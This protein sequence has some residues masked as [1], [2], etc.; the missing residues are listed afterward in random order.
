MSQLESFVEKIRSEQNLGIEVPGFDPKN[1]NEKA[2]FLLILEA[3][4]AK[5]VKTGVISF[6]NPDFTATNL[7]RQL[8][9]AGID[10]SEIAIWNVVPWYLGNDEKTKIRPAKT[11][12]ISQCLGYL[13]ELVSLL[14]RLECVVLV[15]AAARKAH[16][17]LS[18]TTKVRILSCHH[19]SPRV[20][21]H[22]SDAARDNIAVFKAM[23]A[24]G[25]SGVS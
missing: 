2:R 11:R 25:M 1:G 10:R 23:K 9:V 12:D 14:N 5:A 22:S 8:E 17:H 21:N 16:V 7:K 6:D 19:P 24:S 18:Y 13:A 4:G 15:G 3:P 20:M